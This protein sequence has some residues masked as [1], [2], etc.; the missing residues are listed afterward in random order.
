MRTKRQSSNKSRKN[1]EQQPETHH[2]ETLVD[3]GT[4]SGNNTGE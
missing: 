1:K 2:G 3:L 4:G